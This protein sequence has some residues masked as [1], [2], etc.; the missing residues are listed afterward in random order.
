MYSFFSNYLSKRTKTIT[1]NEFL[2][3]KNTA[4]IVYI[5]NLLIYKK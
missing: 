1:S 3:N 5:V 2:K 4:A